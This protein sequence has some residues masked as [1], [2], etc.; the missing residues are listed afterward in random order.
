MTTH[1]SPEKL[2]LEIVIDWIYKDPE[3]CG[4]MPRHDGLREGIA[5]A[6]QAE[7]DRA[8]KLSDAIERLE[9]IL[10][11]NGFGREAK[12]ALEAIEGL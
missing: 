3:N 4:V 6:L 1:K 11:E 2:A 10:Y 7:R 8:N 9:E 12:S 5:L